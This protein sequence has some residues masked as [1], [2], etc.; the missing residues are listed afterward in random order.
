M[1]HAAGAPL[2][3]CHI[4][5]GRTAELVAI[6]KAQGVDVTAE[7]AAQYLLLDEDTYQIYG[8]RV[9]VTPPLRSPEDRQQLWAA[10]AEGV[11][12]AVAC[13]H[14][15]ENLSPAP[16]DPRLIASAAAGIAGLELS[17]PLILSAGVLAGRLSLERFV[18]ATSRR[19]AEIAGLDARKGSLEPGKDADF[20]LFD[21]AAQ[22]QAASLGPFSRIPTTP[23]EGWSLKGRI[24]QTWVRGRLVWDG[25]EITTAPEGGGG[26]YQ[27]RSPND[28][29]ID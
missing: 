20:F 10:L 16:K 24:R 23:F 25:T 4:S 13:D 19:P 7:T 22:W 18:S 3:I 11:I 17:L 8:P 28:R 14:Y 21:P 5:T 27:R 6:A 15:I 9:K 1:A 29:L 26:T 12:D 2:H